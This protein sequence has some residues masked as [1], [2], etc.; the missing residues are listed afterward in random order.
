MKQRHVLR[1]FVASP[2]DVQVERDALEE[3]AEDLNRNIARSRNIVIE[4][5]RWETDSYPGFH[6]DGPQAWIDQTTDIEDCDI[7]IGIFWK[8][9]GTPTPDAKS[10]TEHEFRKAYKSWKQNGHPHIMMYFNQSYYTLTSKEE[11]EQL[12]QVLEFKQ[13]FPREGLFWTYKGEDDF[14]NKVRNHLSQY[15]LE[16]IIPDSKTYNSEAVT[17]KSTRISPPIDEQ[18]SL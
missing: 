14:K 6:L 13:N 1:V 15:I 2:G 18:V 8:R 17:K 11:A 7:L 9:F 12:G 4:I 5:S 3:V 16:V 10:G